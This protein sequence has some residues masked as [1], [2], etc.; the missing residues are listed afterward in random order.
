MGTLITLA[1]FVLLTGI[2]VIFYMKRTPSV[3]TIA[4]TTHPCPRCQDPVPDPARNCPSCGIPQQIFELATAKTVEASESSGGT[5]HALVRK[6]VCVGCGTCVDACPEAGAIFLQG[7]LAI[8][9]RD[10]R[11]AHGE[12]V[13]ACPVGAIALSE[14]DAV[15][16]IEVPLTNSAFESNVSGV[17][18]VGEL[19]GRGL[20]KNAVNE[21]KIAVEDI[22]RKVAEAP[23]TNGSGP[24]VHDVAVIGSGPAGLSA[25]LQAL[26]S[27]LDY[28]V[29]EQ[30][31]LADTIRKYPRH[32]FLLAEPINIPLYGDLWVAD[33]SKETLLQLWETVIENTGLQVHTNHRVENLSPGDDR[34]EIQTDQG[35]FLARNVVLAMGRRGTPRRLEVPGEELDKVF[36]DIVERRPSRAGTCWWWGA[37]TVRWNRLW[38]SP[39]RPVRRFTS[40]IGAASSSE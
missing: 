1:F 25:G 23:H 29:L 11:V 10:I 14:G 31:N 39:T 2:L 30:G 15:Q 37:A 33:A 20:I 38:G 26:R 8:V 9:D 16:R 36:Y 18:I 19:G 34:V 4:P 24:R 40:R 5:L 17:Y 35:T 27:Q 3:E 7:K 28:V 13:Q 12:C 21:G 32:K 6:D 22:A